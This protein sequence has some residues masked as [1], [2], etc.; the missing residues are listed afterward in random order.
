MLSVLAALAVLLQ[1]ETP[2]PSAP[3]DPP[4]LRRPSGDDMARHYPESAIKRGMSGRVVIV[5]GVTAEG[6]LTACRVDSELPKAEG[7][8]EAALR[9]APLFKL[10]ANDKSGRSVE[11]GVLRIPLRFVMPPHAERQT[12]LIA[13]MTCYGHVANQAERTPTAPGAWQA[14]VYWS[15]QTA[16]AAANA[17][18]RPSDYQ[19]ALSIAHREVRERELPTPHGELET[20]L[21]KGAKP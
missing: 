21:A 8:G 4:W 14:A 12:K 20:C 11:G 3:L 6:S 10:R 1:A 18:L 19:D 16:A 13:A 7:F 5:C 17:G 15:L 2:P 9:M